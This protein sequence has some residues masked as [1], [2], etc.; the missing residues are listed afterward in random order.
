[1]HVA[2]DRSETV[3]SAVLERLEVASRAQVQPAQPGCATITFVLFQ[4]GM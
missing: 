1:M 4:T 3:P 2:R